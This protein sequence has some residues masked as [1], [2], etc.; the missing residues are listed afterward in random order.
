MFLCAWVLIFW[1]LSNRTCV[2]VCLCWCVCKRSGTYSAAFICVCEAITVSLFWFF[3]FSSL[4]FLFVRKKHLAVT[5]K[6]TKTK[7]K[8][9]VCINK[10]MCVYGTQKKVRFSKTKTA[11]TK[12]VQNFSVH[13]NREPGFASN[14]I[15]P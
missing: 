13:W 14:R 5:K 10:Q 12:L 2:Y 8:L 1:V 3:P 7:P 6:Q 11:I 4:F 9:P 15:A